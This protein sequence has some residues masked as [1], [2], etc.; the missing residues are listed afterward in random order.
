M[1]DEANKFY[2]DLLRYSAMLSQTSD[3]PA[4]RALVELIREAKERASAAEEA[5]ELA[6]E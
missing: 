3:A 4:I 2:R 1:M 5:M 6:A